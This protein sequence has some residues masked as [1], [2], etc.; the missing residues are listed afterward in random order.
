MPARA[1]LHRAMQ[2]NPVLVQSCV[3]DGRRVWSRTLGANPMQSC[4][5]KLLLMQL[6]YLLGLRK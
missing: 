4:T 6:E 5:R 2:E 3:W 1:I